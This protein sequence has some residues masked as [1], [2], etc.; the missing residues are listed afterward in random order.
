[1]ES[2]KFVTGIRKLEWIPQTASGFRILFMTDFAYEQL[3]ARA[4]VFIYSNAEGKGKDFIHC[5]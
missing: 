1:M 3:K 5:Q 4:G 2:V